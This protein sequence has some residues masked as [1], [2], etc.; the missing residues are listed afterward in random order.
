MPDNPIAPEEV[1][2]ILEK[3]PD[4]ET[5]RGLKQMEQIENV[6][7]DGNQLEVTIALTSY[8]APL[9]D[10]T[11]QQLKKELR[12]QLPS[13]PDVTVKVAELS[14]AA[15]PIGGIG[16]TVKS[17][18]AVGSGKGGVGKS[19]VAASLAVGL[20]RSGC[21]VGLMDADVYGPSIPHLLGVDERP[22]ASD[23][24]AKSHRNRRFEG[25]EHG[26]S[27]SSWRGRGVARPDAARRDHA[28]SARHRLGKSRLS[29]HRHA[30]WHR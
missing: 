11:Q 30:T 29:D 6:K 10:E 21:T 9:W 20:R 19:T 24:T 7:I 22:T 27:R 16:L 5:G 8:S 2:K 15:E 12:T 28:I 3:F 17:V 4:P 25:N 14:R 1:D 18:I 23:K 26:I 13:H